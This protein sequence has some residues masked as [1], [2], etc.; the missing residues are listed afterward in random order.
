MT[1]MPGLLTLPIE[2]D[3]GFNPGD[4]TYLDN[5]VRDPSAV[6]VTLEAV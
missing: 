5:L 1:N 2:R 4:F 3:A 6:S